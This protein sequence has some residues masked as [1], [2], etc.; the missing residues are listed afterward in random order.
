MKCGEAMPKYLLHGQ[1]VHG[2][3]G[4]AI[5]IGAVTLEVGA[6]KAFCWT[7]VGERRPKGWFRDAV[8]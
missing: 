7:N 1:D 2:R 4:A 8:R 6:L 5:G 3:I